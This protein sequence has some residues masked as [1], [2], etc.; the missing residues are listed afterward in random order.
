MSQSLERRYVCQEIHSLGRRA[1]ITC[2]LA[3]Q[4]TSVRQSTRHTGNSKPHKSSNKS[5]KKASF[6]RSSDGRGCRIGE[7]CPLLASPAFCLWEKTVLRNHGLLFPISRVPLIQPDILCAGYYFL[8]SFPAPTDEWGHER[9]DSGFAIGSQD[10]AREP[11]V[12]L[13]GGLVA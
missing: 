3:S 12:R 7:G 11:G 9:R 8:A 6:C 1:C 2:G 4:S 5:N 13:A 10:G